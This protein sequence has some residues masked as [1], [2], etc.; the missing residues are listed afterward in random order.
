MEMS[1]DFLEIIGAVSLSGGTI[2]AF[3][4]WLFKL[5]SDKWLTAKFAKRLEDHKHSQQKDLENVRFEISKIMDRTIKL[6]QREFDILP[7]AWEL[8]VDANGIASAVLSPLQQ[9]A[10]VARMNDSQL[11]KFLESSHLEDWEKDELKSASN[12]SEYYWKSL[13]RHRVSE[14]REAVRL[15]HVYRLKNGIFILAEINDK[16]EQ[17]DNLLFKA[18]NERVYHLQDEQGVRERRE[19]KAWDKLNADGQNLMKELETEIHDRLW[20]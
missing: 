10:D 19:S 13:Q 17:I 18:V 7:K 12:K 14:A 9:Y 6:H 8:L 3:T 4:Y 2:V 16:L 20:N 15:F 11:D 1:W 5:F